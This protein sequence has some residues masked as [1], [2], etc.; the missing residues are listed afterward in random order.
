MIWSSL[1]ELKL[2]NVDY[3]FDNNEVGN[4]L[5]QLFDDKKSKINWY[6][7]IAFIHYLC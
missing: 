3:L 5:N 1:D 2:E 6:H 7:W 4:K